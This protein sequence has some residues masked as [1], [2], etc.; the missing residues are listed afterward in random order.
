MKGEKEEKE[1]KE[2]KNKKGDEEEKEEKDVLIN[3]NVFRMP[4]KLIK[5]AC[6]N[7]VLLNTPPAVCVGSTAPPPAAI[8]AHPPLPHAFYT[9]SLHESN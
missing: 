3:L 8:Q 7:S 4:M 9:P 6:L 2:E 1:E 5:S